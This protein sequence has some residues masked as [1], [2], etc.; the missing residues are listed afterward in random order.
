MTSCVS[1]EL[2]LHVPRYH[3]FSFLHYELNRAF[4]R[5]RRPPLNPGSSDAARGNSPAHPEIDL[6]ILER[7]PRR[8]QS[9]ETP[10]Y[11]PTS[12]SQVYPSCGGDNHR[13]RS[14]PPR[15]DRKA[16]ANA[17]DD[18]WPKNNTPLWVGDAC[19]GKKALCDS[20][21]LP[22]VNW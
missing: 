13:D 10:S 17:R 9:P 19:F 12:T 15:L 2:P 4:E 7:Q 22:G 11:E 8:Q 18:Q 21:L 6:Y 3:L 14:H 16:S 5:D 20:E 1:Y